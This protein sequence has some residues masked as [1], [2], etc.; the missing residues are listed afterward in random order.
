[1]CLYSTE[2]AK[3]H[4]KMKFWVDFDQYF[5]VSIDF[6]LNTLIVYIGQNQLHKFFHEILHVA[7]KTNMNLYG[8]KKLHL[9]P[10][11]LVL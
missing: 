10:E 6:V 2:C 5:Y 1:M 9:C 11:V 3:F 8:K 7:V 4:E